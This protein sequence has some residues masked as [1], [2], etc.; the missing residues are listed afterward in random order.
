MCLLATNL[1]F[2]HI[3]L[4]KKEKE[5]EKSL[6][7]VSLIFLVVYSEIRIFFSS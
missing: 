7:E 5:K 4:A 3:N 2:D 1:I 6:Q